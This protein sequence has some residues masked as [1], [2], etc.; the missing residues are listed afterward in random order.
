MRTIY[1]LDSI[2]RADSPTAHDLRD[3]NIAPPPLRLYHCIHQN[4]HPIKQVRIIIDDRK[5]PKEEEKR[6]NTFRV[7]LSLESI[8]TAVLEH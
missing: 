7:F 8:K 5:K 1:L 3:I 2:H 4:R 6:P